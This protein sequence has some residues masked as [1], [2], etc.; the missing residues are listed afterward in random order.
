MGNAYSAVAF[1]G[2]R[3]VRRGPDV[4]SSFDTS[5]T[6]SFCKS[7]KTG[8]GHKRV[9]PIPL[10]MSKHSRDQL[11]RTSSLLGDVAAEEDDPRG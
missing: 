10:I 4:R 3:K 1:L 9:K 6:N 11:K 5:E 7:Y 2:G 8:Y